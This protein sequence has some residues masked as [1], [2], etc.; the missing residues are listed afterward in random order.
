M[1]FSLNCYYMTRMLKDK[2]IN[3]V[4][5]IYD[6]EKTYSV[7]RMNNINIG[8]LGNMYNL[9]YEATH[10]IDNIYLGNG[11]N[12]SNWKELE[13]KNIGLII[14]ITNEIPNYYSDNIEYYNIDIKDIGE[15]D[16]HPYL[17]KFI[18][19]ITSF[20][21]YNIE[22]KNILIHCYMGSSRS[23][24]L[25]VA[26]LIK[27]KDMSIDKAINFIINKREIVNINKKFIEDL[28]KWNNEI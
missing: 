19:K 4:Y 8:F 3:K 7:R 10:I 17:D 16:L 28:K 22:N 25:V 12:A 2:I 14:N 23:A 6:S 27:F 13:T 5:E 18:E 26:Y 15:S 21:K 11:Y 20:K 9:T 1:N 24:S